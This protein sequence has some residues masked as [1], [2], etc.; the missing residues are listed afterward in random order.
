[1][2]FD[3]SQTTDP[4]DYAALIPHGTIATVQMRIR[5]GSV[6]EDGMLKRTAKGDAEMLDCEFVIVDGDHAKRKFWDNFLLEGTTPDQQAMALTNRGRLKKILESARGIKSGDTSEQALAAYKAD[7]KDF[8]NILFIA[9]IGVRKG[10]PKK[11][12]DGKL[13]GGN[14]DDKNYLAAAIGP[15][16]KEWHPVEQPP[17]FNGDG[18]A[19]AAASGPASAPAST[20]TDSTSAPI[21]PPAW[22]R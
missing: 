7:L 19:A 16:H 17:P 14:W 8:D 10:E 22:A 3:Y 1:M 13:T 12:K 6:G 21:T 20:S 11:D 4:R 15:D 2:P 18:G 9:K 5:P